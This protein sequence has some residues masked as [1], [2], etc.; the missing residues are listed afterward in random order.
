MDS[1]YF[2]NHFLFATFLT[3]I[4]V[5]LFENTYVVLASLFYDGK[6]LDQPAM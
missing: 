5:F 3:Y 2:F 1:G 4:L 6:K